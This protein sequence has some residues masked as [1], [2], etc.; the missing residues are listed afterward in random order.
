MTAVL[1]TR[2]NRVK[3]TPAELVGVW[4]LAGF[5]FAGFFSLPI[6]GRMPMLAVSLLG[7][8]SILFYTKEQLGRIRLSLPIIGMLTW[9]VMSILWSTAPWRSTLSVEFYGLTTIAM[10]CVVSVMSFELIIK[11]LLKGIYGTV[12]LTCASLVIAPGTTMVDSN[13]YRSIHGWFFHKN[14][15]AP[16]MVMAIA[17]TVALEKRPRVRFWMTFLA[18][19]LIIGSLSATGLIGLV[20]VVGFDYMVRHLSTADRARRATMVFSA[21]ALS[22]LLTFFTTTFLPQIVGV[23]GKDTTFSGRT[24]IWRSVWQAILRRPITGYGLDAAFQGPSELVNTFYTEIGFVPAHAHNGILDVALGLG[25][26]G[27]VLALWCFLSVWRG[28]WRYAS[29]GVAFA[30]VMFVITSA[31]LIMSITE[32]M[33]G[34]PTVLLMF[35]FRIVLLRWRAGEPVPR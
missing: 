8:T 27:A 33:L 24:L 34:W 3:Y 29:E 21:M 10:I 32:S 28:S 9:T 12:V 1:G 6:S 14:S 23:Y 18:S 26:V 31:I 20:V 16:Y 4:F 22:V 25:L 7:G 35:T 19:A 5:M 13:G 17:F 2:I 15:M 11:G 30:R